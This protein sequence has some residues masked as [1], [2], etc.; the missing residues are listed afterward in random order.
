MKRILLTAV[1][2]VGLVGAASAQSV[3]GTLGALRTTVA[4]LNAT[5]VSLTRGDAGATA[6]NL[7]N[8]VN[9]LT[10]GLSTD[11]PLAGLAASGHDVSTQL[12]NM[13]LT[14]T[15]TDL[16]T[17]QSKPV[18]ALLAPFSAQ[19]INLV[20]TLSTLPGLGSGEPGV[21]PTP[22][23][24]D[25]LGISA[26]AALFSN[27]ISSDAFLIPGLDA[28]PVNALPLDALDGLLGG[29][30]LPGL[31]DAGLPGAG[32]GLP[33]LDSLTGLLDPSILLGLLNGG[34]PTLPGTV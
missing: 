22:G 25:S 28:L 2:T 31:G 32:A 4:N 14:H 9:G 17:E 33:G 15:V 5:T 24:S 18:V 29:A 16:I 1:M 30:S 34:L 8:T 20:A 10:I 7:S 19:G 23:N 11:T 12:L 26:L 21:A 27:I 3:S 6:L 13:S